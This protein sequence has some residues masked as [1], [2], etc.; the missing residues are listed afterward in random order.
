M[1]DKCVPLM[2]VFKDVNGSIIMR[3]L[4]ETG[5]SAP[6]LHDGSPCGSDAN[7]ALVFVQ[8]DNVQYE[9]GAIK[10]RNRQAPHAKFQEIQEDRDAAAKL[11]RRLWLQYGAVLQ[12]I[13]DK[14]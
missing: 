3:T 10:F 14:I 6:F 9:L 11:Y 12:P 4:T 8:I 5:L 7:V 13:L 1:T 2:L